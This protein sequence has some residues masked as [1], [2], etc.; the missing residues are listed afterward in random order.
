[1]FQISFGIPYLNAEN[2]N[3]VCDA[4]FI[5]LA[6]RYKWQFTAEIIILLIL[7]FVIFTY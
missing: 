2:I 3:N 1:M 5:I 4:E 6:Y 7:C